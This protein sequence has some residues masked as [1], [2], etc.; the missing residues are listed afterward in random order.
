M[1][2]PNRVRLYLRGFEVLAKE[3]FGWMGKWFFLQPIWILNRKHIAGGLGL[4]VTLAFV[5]LPIQ[6]FLCVPLSIILRVNLPAAL[7][8]VW[9]SNPLTAAPIFFFALRVGQLATNQTDSWEIANATFSI[10][11]MANLME[12]IWVPLFTGCAIC[13]SVAGL[14]TYLLVNFCWRL[15]VAYLRSRK[16]KR[17]GFKP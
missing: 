16:R 4:G 13:G 6:M 15:Q 9:L 11:D 1:L 14:T 7:G 5:P 10:T 2:S 3:K 12:I 8:A 17:Q